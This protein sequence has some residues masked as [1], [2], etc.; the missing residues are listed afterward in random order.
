MKEKTIIFRDSRFPLLITID[1]M[2]I[3]DGQI[4]YISNLILTGRVI[5]GPA[6]AVISGI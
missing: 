1:Q 4:L 3:I 2:M 5:G 6:E